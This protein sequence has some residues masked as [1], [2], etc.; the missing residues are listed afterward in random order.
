MP[1]ED[2]LYY[3]NIPFIVCLK[4]KEQ[5]CYGSKEKSCSQNNIPEFFMK[6]N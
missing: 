1:F 6:M 4:C 2:G 5:P 3:G